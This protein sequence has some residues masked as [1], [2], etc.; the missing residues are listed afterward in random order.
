MC[1]T[2]FLLKKPEKWRHTHRRRRELQPFLWLLLLSIVWFKV[3]PLAF[4]SSC[5]MDEVSLPGL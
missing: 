3:V 1:K 4:S 2:G 5:F